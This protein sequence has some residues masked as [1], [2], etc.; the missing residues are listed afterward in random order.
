MRRTGFPLLKVDL[1]I[2]EKIEPYVPEG[3][4]LVAAAPDGVEETVIE[5]VGYENLCY[6]IVD[7]PDLVKRVFDEV[8][9][10]LLDYYKRVVEYENFPNIEFFVIEYL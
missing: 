7:E 2:L 6:M 8:G 10:R 3:M 5:L 1:S 4:K 9:Q